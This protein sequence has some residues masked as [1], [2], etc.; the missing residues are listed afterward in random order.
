MRFIG[1]L[2]VA[3]VI[4]SSNSSAE[5]PTQNLDGGLGVMWEGPVSGKDEVPANTIGVK[6]G[7][8]SKLCRGTWSETTGQ[9]WWRDI[10]VVRQDGCFTLGVGH[11]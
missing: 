8:G 10:G 2:M 6:I 5:G 4:G 3:G 11:V 1:L 7:R 9:N